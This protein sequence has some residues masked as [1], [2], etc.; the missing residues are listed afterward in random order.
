MDRQ[1]LRSDLERLHGE[2]RAINSVDEEERRMLRQLECDIEELLARSD[3]DLKTDQ[4]A[5]QLLSDLLA[6]VEA[7]RNP[8]NGTDG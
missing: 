1:K 6:R 8:G 4:D 3:D 7:S 5:R 2:L